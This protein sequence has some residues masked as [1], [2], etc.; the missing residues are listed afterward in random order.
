MVIIEI[1]IPSLIEKNINKNYLLNILLK[2]L[3]KKNFQ[4]KMTLLNSI[5]FISELSVNLYQFYFNEK[6]KEISI[7]NI[8]NDC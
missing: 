6:Q 2:Y 8:Q 5:S 1:T 4:K 7:K 3:K